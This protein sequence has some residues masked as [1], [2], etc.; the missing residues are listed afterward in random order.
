MS[1]KL[2]DAERQQ[3]RQ[4]DREKARQAVE[5]LTSSDGWQRWLSCRRHF[6]TYSLANQL[7]IAHQCPQATRVA[8]FRTW[9]KLGYCVRRGE[10]ALRIWVPIPPTKRQLEQ[11]Q[12]DGARPQDKPRTHFKLGPV[13][14]RSQIA[15]LPPPTQPTPL[16]PPIAAL[17]GDELAWAFPPL[18]KL[19][20]EIACAVLIE[21]IPGQAGGYF[22]PVSRKIALNRERS[23]NHH[24]KTL[25]HELG[26]ALL[27]WELELTDLS[28]TYSEEEL[29]VESIAFTVCGSI[30]LDTTSYSIPYLA[31]W[32]EQ[33]ELETIELAAATIDR[34]AKRIERRYWGAAAG[35]RLTACVR[36]AGARRSADQP[37]DRRSLDVPD[38]LPSIAWVIQLR[39][40]SNRIT[41]WLAESARMELTR[42]TSAS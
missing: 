38:S 28:F 34:I 19:A 9:L 36:L 30:G 39:M 32:A 23:T 26:H 14:D 22:E 35:S 18:V 4:A 15:P 6:H 3:R 29:V 40:S 13:F 12:R 1:T 17:E 8:G 42:L 5:A 33:T 2:T 31:S 16:D 7:L 10:T 37:V 25:V 20:G 27:R 21:R 24:V 41:V 11:W